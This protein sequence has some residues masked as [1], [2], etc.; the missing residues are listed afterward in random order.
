MIGGAKGEIGTYGIMETFPKLSCELRTSILHNGL[1][2]SMKTNNLSEI[3][4][5]IF[6]HRVVG[7]D[8]KKV[9]RFCKTIHN[10]PNGIVPIEST[11]KPSNKIHGYVSHFQEG[12]E[13]GWRV[14]AGLRCSAFTL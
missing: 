9:S 7:F 8:R 4:L 6:L 2:N 3:K 12:I 13:R 1:R 5:C 14:S 10:N 11:R